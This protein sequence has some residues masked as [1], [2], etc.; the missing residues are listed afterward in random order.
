MIELELGPACGVVGRTLKEAPM[1]AGVRV[2]ALVR[3]GDTIVPD[4][5]TE[6]AAGDL[7]IVVAAAGSEA[8]TMLDHWATGPQHQHSGG[9]S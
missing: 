6:L 8:A 9:T 3:G 4:G 2:S 7:L 5:D 1:P